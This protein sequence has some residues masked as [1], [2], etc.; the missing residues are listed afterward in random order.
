MLKDT[1]IGTCTQCENEE[2][3]LIRFSENEPYLCDYCCRVEGIC[4]NCGGYIPNPSD[5][6]RE[7]EDEMEKYHKINESRSDYAPRYCFDCFD[8]IHPNHE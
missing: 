1:I 3:D 2:L 5:E 4:Q 8:I 6:E 7:T